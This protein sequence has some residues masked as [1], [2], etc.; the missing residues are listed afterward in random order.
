MKKSEL[1]SLLKPLI[2]ECINEVLLEEGVLSGVVSE[3]VAGMQGSVITESRR[4][5][6]IPTSPASDNVG[7]IR[8]Q[9]K[10]LMGAIGADAYNG[11]NVFEDTTPLAAAHSP[12]AP[13][14]SV[15]LGNPRDAGVDISSLVGDAS[16]IWQAMK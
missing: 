16:H 6:P 13:G 15:D 8:E 4:P 2:K 14:G 10:K 11:V 7:K 9:K 1:K 5:S 3:V 12:E